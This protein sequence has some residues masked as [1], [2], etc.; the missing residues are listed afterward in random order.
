M[1]ITG[2]EKEKVI[3]LADRSHFSFCL[4]EH[5]YKRWKINAVQIH[6]D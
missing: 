4:S 2:F 1:C 5:K 3:A 6:D